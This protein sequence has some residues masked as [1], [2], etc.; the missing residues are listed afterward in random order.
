M[1]EESELVLVLVGFLIAFLLAFGIGAN[2]VANTFGTSVG[3]KV[4]TLRAACTLAS[5]CELTGSIFL[6][7]QVSET[8]K[9]GIVD[10]ARFNSTSDGPLLLMKGQVSSLA[11]AC[12]WM[13]IATFFRLPVSGTHS[14]VGATAGYGLVQFGIHGIKWM[15]VL[16]IVVSW[17]AAPILSGGVSFIIFFFIK[18]FVLSKE[19]PL[20]PALRSLPF[21][22]ACTIIVNVFSVLFGGIPSFNLK[23]PLWAV[24][25]ASFASG[26]VIGLIVYLLVVPFVRKRTLL[27]VELLKQRELEGWDGTSSVGEPS[28]FRAFFMT[29]YKRF[30]D[31]VH[32]R[33]CCKGHSMDAESGLHSSTSARVSA[34]GDMMP[35]PIHRNEVLSSKSELLHPVA[36]ESTFDCRETPERTLDGDSFSKEKIPDSPPKNDIILLSGTDV[37][38]SEDDDAISYSEPAIATD[39]P[40]EAKVFSYAQILTATFGSFVHGGNDVSNAIG[41]LIGLWIVSTTGSVTIDKNTPIL[42]LVYGGVGISVGLWVWGRRVIQTIGEDLTAM[43]PSSG[44]SIELGS[45]VTALVASKLRIPVSTTHCQVGSVVAVGLARS[46]KSVN[47]KLFINIFVA[48][49]VT[50][51][52][53]AG[54]SALVMYAFTHI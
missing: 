14:I 11:G 17:F 38:A 24:F 23:I 28:R 46:R 7:G 1:L 42:L 37:T 52:A 40:E 53:S 15:G 44:V 48:W 50:L 45:A 34:D 26:L 6:G 36:S 16:K 49:V 2:D 41:P 5:I 22:F 47:W 30:L 54:I 35:K 8:I 19:K 51:P 12:I 4:L 25:V 32:C 9:N 27:Y 13:L 43:T 29:S 10:T 33:S 31:F 21:I 20:E 39:R 3:A 18:R